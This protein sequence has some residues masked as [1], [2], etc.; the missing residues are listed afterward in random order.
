MGEEF[1]RKPHASQPQNPGHGYFYGFTSG[2]PSTSHQSMPSPSSRFSITEQHLRS[3]SGPSSH[4]PQPTTLSHPSGSVRPSFHHHSLSADSSSPGGSLLTYRG[5]PGVQNGPAMPSPA[6]VSPT[7][8]SPSMAAHK[9]AFRQRRK[10]PS[11]DACRE[12]K[13]KVARPSQ[14]APDILTSTAVRCYGDLELFR[15]FEQNCQVPIHQRDQ[16]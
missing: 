5:D 3:P 10:D 4:R 2:P 9:R 15:M 8:P 12:R 16:P 6:F 14:F 11:C 1:T 13:V 7:Y